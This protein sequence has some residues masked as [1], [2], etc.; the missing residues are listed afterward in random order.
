MKYLLYCRK[1]TDSEDRQMLSLDSQEKELLD[2]AEY[3]G[4]KVSKVLR[5][6]QSAKAEGRPVFDALLREL[7]SGKADAILCWKLDRLARNMADAGRVIDML[8]RG[9]IKEIKTHDATHL[10]TDNVLMLAV[11]L[12]MA[13]QY[14]RD[15]SE[16]VKRGNRTKL[17]QGGWPNKAPF[18]YRNDPITKGLVIHDNERALIIRAF[19]LFATGHY[20]LNEVRRMLNTEGF[21]TASGTELN[22]SL[23]ERIIKNP[24]YMGVMLSHGKYY[25]GTHEPIVSKALYDQAQAVLNGTTRPKSQTLSFPLRGILRCATCTCQYTASLKKGHTY[26]YCTNGKGSCGAHARYLRSEPAT[27][28]VAD[29]L[30]KVRIDRNL[31]EIMADAKRELYA[32]AYSYTETIQKR[33]QG[34]IDTLEKQEIKLF[35]DSSTGII[36]KDFYIRQMLSIKNKKTLL[37]KDLKELKLQN[38]LS[39]LEPIKEAFIQGSTAQNRFLIADPEQQKIVASEVLWNLLVSEGKTQEIRYKSFYQALANAPKNASLEIMLGD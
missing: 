22:K 26:Y 17:E 2:L 25:V 6:S 32:D 9:V 39:T 35:E 23:I 38:G 34:Q 30:E 3:Q 20:A 4:L 8:Q 33:L 21:R 11:Q 18:G 29:A 13:N 5:E 36:S 16:N 27:N 1:S 12:G 31:I 14:I 37:Q 28:L 7:Q 10:P 19:D 24:F 15:L